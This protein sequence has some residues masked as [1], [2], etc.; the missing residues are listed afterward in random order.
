M[1]YNLLKINGIAYLADRG[2]ECQKGA[3]IGSKG[4]WNPKKANF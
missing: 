3:H 2:H 4:H 1:R